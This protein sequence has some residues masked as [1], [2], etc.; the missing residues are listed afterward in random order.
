[1]NSFKFLLQ[2]LMYCFIVVLVMYL[3]NFV[4]GV[5]ASGI[6]YG[7]LLVL[8]VLVVMYFK[9]KIKEEAKGG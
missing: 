4:I 7:I 1:M 3:G 2:V 9:G 5:V 8:S 6:Y